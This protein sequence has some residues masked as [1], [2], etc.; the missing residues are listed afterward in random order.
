MLFQIVAILLLPALPTC[1]A[2]V[3]G[4]GQAAALAVPVAPAAAFTCTGTSFA[5]GCTDCKTL[6][7]CLGT[8]TL[9]D[10]SCDTIPATPFCTDG[11]CSATPSVSDICPVTAISC[12][13]VGLYPDPLNCQVYHNC[14]QAGTSNSDPY[15]CPTDYV[16]DAAT[17]VC[18][19]KRTA[20]DCVQVQC[21]TGGVGF[22]TYGTS[23]TYY[24]FCYKQAT[25]NVQVIALLKCSDGAT[26]D[27]SK[28]VYQCK[29]EGSF[30][31]TADPSSYYQCYMVSGKFKVDLKTCPTGKKFDSTKNACV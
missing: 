4:A 9:V 29:K 31:N 6:K 13:G 22:G 12:T 19:Q 24:A 16:F 25:T 15:V 20:A 21:P 17:G 5:T 2:A 7:I 30:P 26:F 27:G 11:S 1:L 8:Q 14:V 23:K 3:A 10:L 28:C 18:K